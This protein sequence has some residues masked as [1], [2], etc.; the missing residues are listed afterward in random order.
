MI[1]SERKSRLNTFF[2]FFGLNQFKV[3]GETSCM[4]LIRL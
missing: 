4:N 3:D 1:S 2:L